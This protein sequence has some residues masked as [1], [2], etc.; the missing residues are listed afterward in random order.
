M[1]RLRT[2]LGL[3]LLASALG[4]WAWA[5]QEAPAPPRIDDPKPGGAVL[6]RLPQA[7]HEG[8]EEVVVVGQRGHGLPD[9]GSSF[10]PPQA[11]PGRFELK[12]LPLYDPQ[13][14]ERTTDLFAY[15]PEN[16]RIHYI[17][18]FRVQFGRRN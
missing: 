6:A 16:Q 18:L 1:R 2:E 8:I 15:T 17:E 4:S 13:T 14:P 3:T 11:P 12:F 10:Q 9:L 7:N 5:Q